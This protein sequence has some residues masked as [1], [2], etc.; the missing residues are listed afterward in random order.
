MCGR[1]GRGVRTGS[2]RDRSIAR[3]LP[4][5][6][7]PAERKDGVRSLRSSC[8]VLFCRELCRLTGGGLSP[9][10]FASLGLR[11]NL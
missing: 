8:S 10:S 7:R 1:T 3:V 5:N 11:A 2:R 4:R 9:F 6:T